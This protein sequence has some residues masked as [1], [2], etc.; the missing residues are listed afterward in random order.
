MLTLLHIRN[1]V[2]IESLSLDCE[3]GL[4]TLTGETG[5]GKSILL[6]SL[7]LAMGARAESGLVRKGTDQASVTAEFH[8]PANHP[9]LDLLKEQGLPAENNLILRRVLTPDGRSRAFINDE[10]VSISLLKQAGEKLIDIHGQFETYGLLDPASHR[11]ILDGYAGVAKQLTETQSTWKLY[12]DA[13]KKRNQAKEAAEKAATQEQYLR[14]ALEDLEKLNPQSGEE[15]ELLDIRQKM[16]HRDYLAQSI[17]TTEDAL[18]GDEGAEQALASAWRTL[19][20]AADKWG[21]RIQ[22]VL[23]ALDRASTALQ[24]AVQ[25]LN[26]MASSLEITEYNTDS[27]EDRLYELRAEARKHNCLVDDLPAM[28]ETIR[29]QLALIDHQGNILAE[30]DAAVKKS[31]DDYIKAAG[32]LHDMRVKSAENLDKKVNKELPD[33]KLDKAKFLSRIQKQEDPSQWGANGMDVIQFVVSTNAGAEAGPLNKIASGG[34]M[35]RFMLALKVVLAENARHKQTYVFDEIDTG[36]GGATASAVGERLAALAKK[37]QV[38]V[39]TH[40]PQVAARAN[41]HW[42]VS[43]S[44]AKGENVITHVMPL[45]E[46]QSRREEIARMLSGAT[47]TEEARAAAAR[48]L[49][50]SA[51]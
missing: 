20:R 44:A 50:A 24:D 5:A 33:L 27:L 12:Q 2:L 47:I 8:M 43:K 48:L 4:T 6:D 14:H 1:V 31:Q 36:I 10:P 3:Q 16:Q 32:T 41:H 46:S 42:I 25:A 26:G 21:D 35:A 11:T 17:S 45:L 7:G 22:P 29:N 15:Q 13:I 51:A 38:L 49:E 30:L 40:S 19:H 34:E 28:R 39:V 23:D 18:T 37:H 9:V